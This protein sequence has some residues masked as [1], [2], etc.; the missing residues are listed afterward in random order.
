M[1]IRTH[2]SWFFV[3]ILVAG[4]AASPALARGGGSSKGPRF[5]HGYGEPKS[6]ATYGHETGGEKAHYE[7][8]ERTT[9]RAYD[10]VDNKGLT[11]AIDAPVREE[12][13]YEAHESKSTRAN[14][15]TAGGAAAGAGGA[16]TGGATKGGGTK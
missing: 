15:T 8:T 3:A 7:K 5:G 1:I 16:A 6:D 13:T 10:K 11:R 4:L 14:T 2:G 12:R 9:E